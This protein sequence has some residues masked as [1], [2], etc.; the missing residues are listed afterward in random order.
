MEQLEKHAFVLNGN[1]LEAETALLLELAGTFP[2]DQALRAVNLPL[3][4]PQECSSVFVKSVECSLGQKHHGHQ[5]YQLA[6][7]H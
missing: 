3:T 4:G 2:G 1:I 7:K 5:V 6:V